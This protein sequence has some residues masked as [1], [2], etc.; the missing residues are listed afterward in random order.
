MIPKKFHFIF[1]LEPQDLPFHITHYL[2]LLS[3]IKVNQPDEVHFYCQ[4][5]PFG[6]YWEIIKHN[7]IL[8][9]VSTIQRLNGYDLNYAHQSDFLRLELLNRHG[10]V[11]ADMDTIFVNTLKEEFYRKDF[12][13]GRED[14]PYPFYGLCNAFMMA[15]SGSEFGNR[16]LND[17][18]EAYNGSWNY[19]SVR[20]PK[21]LALAHPDLIHIEPQESFY[22]HMW[23]EEGISQLYTN[24]DRNLCNNY[25][26]HLWNHV[27]WDEHLA[28]LTEEDIM[29]RDSTYNL[30]ARSVLSLT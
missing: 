27:A 4:H 25:C 9:Y 3:C 7:L 19:H 24:I 21:E 14:I 18:F 10:G 6:P 17:I 11:Y 12:V 2:C 8:H 23:D 29:T 1:G 20:L 16:W 22:K 30:I 26:L 28:N 13:M 15:R 5:E